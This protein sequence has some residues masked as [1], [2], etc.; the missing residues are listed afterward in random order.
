MKRVVTGLLL[1]ILSVQSFAQVTYPSG[2]VYDVESNWTNW[3]DHTYT[4]PIITDEGGIPANNTY[5]TAHGRDESV[6]FYPYDSG[7]G[8]TSGALVGN[9]WEKYGDRFMFVVDVRVETP[10][11]TLDQ[12]YSDFYGAGGG[13]FDETFWS[14]NQ[15]AA[16][17]WV[18]YSIEFDSSWTTAE[19]IAAGWND[20]GSNNFHDTYAGMTK[21]QFVGGRAAAGDNTEFQISVDNWGFVVLSDT[22]AG[23]YNVESNQ[24][25][26]RDHTYALPIVTSVHEVIGTVPN[27]NTYFTSHARDESVWFYPYDSGAA[28]TSGFL[29]GDLFTKYGNT[30]EFTVDVKVETPA[31][32]LD[33]LRIEFDSRNSGGG[34]WDHTYWS[35]NQTAADGWVTYTMPID[36]SWTTQDAKDN[37]WNDRASGLFYETFADATKYQY[38]YGYAADGDGTEFQ[39][40]VDNWGFVPIEELPAEPN[41]F[42]VTFEPE[43]QGAWLWMK[44]GDH[45]AITGT[46]D[47]VSGGNPGLAM[48]SNTGLS[49]YIYFTNNSGAGS[50][51]FNGNL[52]DKYTDRMVFTADVKVVS[53]VEVQNFYVEVPGQL[54]PPWYYFWSGPFDP[55]Q[56]VTITAPIDQFWKEDQTQLNK[57]FINGG[58]NSEY[59]P[60]G[61][62]FYDTFRSVIGQSVTLGAR[63]GLSGGTP[64]SFQFVV[65]NIGFVETPRPA[66]VEN[67][68]FISLFQ[69]SPDYTQWRSNGTNGYPGRLETSDDKREG[70]GGNPGGCTEISRPDAGSLWLSPLDSKWTQDDGIDRTMIGDLFSKFGNQIEFTVDVR[71]MTEGVTVTQFQYSHVGDHTRDFSDPCIPAGVPNGEWVNSWT[72]NWTSADGWITLKVPMDSAW[73]DAQATEHGWVNENV[74]SFVDTVAS[75]FKWSQISV[76]TYSPDENGITLRIDNYG[77]RSRDC[78][79]LEHPYPGYDLNQDCTVN[80]GDYSGLAADWMIGMGMDDLAGMGADWLIDNDPSH[81]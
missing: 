25:N 81:D 21:S 5:F 54:G 50:V 80:L 19:A 30:L 20:R 8:G 61:V 53:N 47:L 51:Y 72:G 18:T 27:Y 16:D 35:A 66:P 45:V 55:N 70:I 33:R 41:S 71:I 74:D 52:F 58:F 28:G 62:L 31:F 15:T 4:L 7:A 75:T 59:N 17:G 68:G 44:N 73:S 77:Y 22:P 60:D 38:V 78:G 11:F 48:P 24:T 6:W 43:Q 56:W 29:V 76:Q 69:N 42:I 1:A 67:K 79:D 3:R 23:V 46:G 64:S 12:V 10:G 57:W 13:R 9:L 36:A 26:W 65:D 14:V 2:W 63:P 49:P 32:A 34:R 39:I 40:S 37:G